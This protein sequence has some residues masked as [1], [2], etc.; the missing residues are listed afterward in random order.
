MAKGRK[1]GGQEAAQ[2]CETISTRINELVR[3]HKRHK[4][5]G[6]DLSDAIKKC[7]VDSGFNTAAIKRLVTARAGERFHEVK[8]EVEQLS[9]IFTEVG[10]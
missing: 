8:R 1:D 9:L 10:E 6:E 3:L 7:A 5:A 4:D 2:N